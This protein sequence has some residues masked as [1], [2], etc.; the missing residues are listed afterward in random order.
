MEMSASGAGAEE[1]KIFP[2][3][4]IAG[5]QIVRIGYSIGIVP[6]EVTVKS[7]TT[8]IWVF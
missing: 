3:K 8:V 4:K 1:Q 5:S 2:E 7:G 6:A